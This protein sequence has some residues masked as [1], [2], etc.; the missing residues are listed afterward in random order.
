MSLD[1][2]GGSARKAQSVFGWSSKTV[3]LGLHELRTGINCIDNFSLRGRHR[4]EEVQPQL[5]EDSL[6]LV[7]PHSQTDPK[8]QGPFQ[9]TRLTAKAVRQALIAEK[10]WTDA[11]LPHENTLGVI[12][13]RQ[14]YRLRRVQ[15]SK[16]IKCVNAT[17][18]IFATV[19]AENEKSDQRPDSLQVSIDTKAKVDI[20]PFSRR[21]CS[22]G[23]RAVEATDHDFQPAYKLV[24]FG[25]LDVMAGWLTI[26]FG[27][28]RETSDFIVDGL[29]QSGPSG[30]LRVHHPA[31][32][33]P[34]QWPRATESAHAVYGAPG[35]VRRGDRPGDRPRLIPAV[36]LQI[37]S[38]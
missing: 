35:G 31:G 11:Q 19:G 29:Q 10:N 27:S 30:T 3:T 6:A 2:L 9:C 16:P 33:Q 13:N 8:F 1:Y 26:L 17:D 37:Q 7:E 4:C 38:D 18:A 15:K 34:G 22:R 25:I 28:S 20:G 36:A 14:G 5:L 23:A 12:L 32:H 21:G 24:P